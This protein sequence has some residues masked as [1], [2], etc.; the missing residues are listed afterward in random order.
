LSETDPSVVLQP[1]GEFLVVPVQG[2]VNQEL[3]DALTQS[4]LD[5]LS[6]E[7]PTGL[8]FDMAGIQ[9]LDLHD[10][11]GLRHLV[12]SAQLMGAPSAFAG[13]QPGVA[14]GLTMLDADGSWIR[15][16]T[17]VER[18]MQLFEQNVA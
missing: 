15:A 4:L 16:A 18:A 6:Y 9:V 3:L 5:Y 8:I 1:V 12:E 10:F 7:N 14:A 11:E 13:I 17:N 2:P